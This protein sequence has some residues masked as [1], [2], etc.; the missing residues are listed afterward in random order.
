[1]ICK[2]YEHI[3]IVNDE[4]KLVCQA[5]KI[6]YNDY[7]ADVETHKFDYRRSMNHI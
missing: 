5:C 1:M 2:I 3:F 4:D 6:T 7:L